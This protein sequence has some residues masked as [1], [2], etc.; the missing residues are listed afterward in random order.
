MHPVTQ[1]DVARLE[2]RQRVAETA[3]LASVL[4]LVPRRTRRGAGRR[5]AAVRPFELASTQHAQSVPRWA[6]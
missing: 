1:L 3:R 6:L 2:H 4:R 5:R